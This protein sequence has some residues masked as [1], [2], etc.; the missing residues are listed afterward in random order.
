[1]Q[2]V[3][4]HIAGRDDVLV[5][6]GPLTRVYFCGHCEKRDPAGYYHFWTMKNEKK[7]LW[8]GRCFHDKDPG[9]RFRET[10]HRS[11]EQEV[12]A[13]AQTATLVRPSSLQDVEDWLNHPSHVK[14]APCAQH[15]ELNGQPIT[16]GRHPVDGHYIVQV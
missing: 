1:M 7:K 10:E 6:P 13:D 9:W 3:Y 15:G 5:E 12:W 4:T 11:N 14:D 2:P 16:I 8:P